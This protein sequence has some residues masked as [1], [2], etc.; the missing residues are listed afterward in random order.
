MQ[1]ATTN[2]PARFVIFE[3]AIGRCALLWRSGLV[4]GAALPESHE[5]ALR[6]RLVQR[7]PGA[8]E[9]SPP[10]VIAQAVVLIVRLLAGER[11]DLGAIEVDL[12]GASDLELKVYEAARR[13]PCGQVRTYGELAQ[14]IG[15]PKAAQAVG[16]ALG[17]NPVP[18]VI[19]CHRILASRGGTGGF[20][21]PGGVET[22]FRMLRIEGARRPEE[23]GLF[24]ELPLAVRPRA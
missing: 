22:K 6:A 19:P 15:V 8:E 7:F 16:A 12:T 9:A 3:T 1:A 18:I 24:E 5:G 21:A 11:I 17:R 14:E 4:V 13:I 23:Q 20:S 2:K 10:P